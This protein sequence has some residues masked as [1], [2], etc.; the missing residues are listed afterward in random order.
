MRVNAGSICHSE[1]M[2]TPGFPQT[3]RKWRAFMSNTVKLAVALALT[4]VTATGALAA[5]QHRGT[6]PRAYGGYANSYPNSFDAAYG[7]PV[8]GWANAVPQSYWGAY[9]RAYDAYSNSLDT[10]LGAPPY[11][12][13]Y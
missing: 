3:R 4:A 7:A 6:Y 2:A 5:S 13:Y 12:G 11:A 1:M 10:A 9:R 8:R